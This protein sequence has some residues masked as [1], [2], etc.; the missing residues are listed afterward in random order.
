MGS[1]FSFFG[2]RWRNVGHVKDEWERHAREGEASQVVSK[3]TEA[4]LAEYRDAFNSFDKD[5]GGSIDKA[6]LKEL[7]SSVGQNPTDDELAEMIRIA[8]A[9]GTGDIDFAE[10]VTL[11][12]HK[13]ADEKSEACMRAAFNVFDVSGDGFISAEEMRR[14]M[15]NVSTRAAPR[16]AHSDARAAPYDGM[17]LSLSLSRSLAL[18]LSLSLSL[19][20]MDPC[21]VRS[22]G[23]RA[24]VAGGH[25]HGDEEDRR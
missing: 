25:H 11:M 23:G 16:L 5:G 17:G 22:T 4:Q 8:D 18:A 24:R 2:E 19:S 6:E 1:A 20:L 9:D 13:N 15:I 21:T 3:L 12:A 7:M 14:I 10:F